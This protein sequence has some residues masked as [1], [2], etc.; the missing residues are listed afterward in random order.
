MLY[1]YLVLLPLMALLSM[2]SSIAADNLICGFETAEKA[3]WK[4]IAVV[5]VMRL[6]VGINGNILEK[7]IGILMK[8]SIQAII[9]GM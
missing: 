6:K 9:F 7:N 5:I 4:K 3:G 2:N 8:S 1:R